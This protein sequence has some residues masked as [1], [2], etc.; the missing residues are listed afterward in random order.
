[1]NNIFNLLGIALHWVA[2]LFWPMW[3]LIVYFEGSVWPDP[4]VLWPLVAA[5]YIAPSVIFYVLKGRWIKS[6]WRH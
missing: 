5:T 2:F 6:P 1:M 3:A 4:G